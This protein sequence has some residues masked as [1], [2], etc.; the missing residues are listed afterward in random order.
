MKRVVTEQWIAFDGVTHSTE[1]DCRAY[2]RRVAHIRMV[3]L[4]IED[5][6]AALSRADLDLAEAFEEVARRIKRIRL[7]RSAV[8]TRADEGRE[9]DGPASTG[10]ESEAA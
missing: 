5:V 7:G 9:G 6:E 10:G 1:A 3:G 8:E 2:E 4:K